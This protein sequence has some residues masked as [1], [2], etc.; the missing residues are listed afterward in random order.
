MIYAPGDKDRCASSS[1]RAVRPVADI[2]FGPSGPIRLKVPSRSGGKYQRRAHWGTVPVPVSCREHHQRSNKPAA[3]LL[4]RSSYA[5]QPYSAMNRMTVLRTAHGRASSGGR[6]E[7]VERSRRIN[8]TQASVGSFSRR[9]A[10]PWSVDWL[11]GGEGVESVCMERGGWD[12]ITNTSGQAVLHWPPAWAA[13]RSV[14]FPVTDEVGVRVVVAWALMSRC[15][16]NPGLLVEPNGSLLYS[17]E[18]LSN[19]M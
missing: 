1:S 2:V 10:I 18:P 19:I 7:A 12:S 11:C 6:E 15:Q 9:S 8:S 13:C 14:R 3:R 16:D 5:A 4:P 17:Q